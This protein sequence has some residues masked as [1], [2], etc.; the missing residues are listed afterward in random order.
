MNASPRLFILGEGAGDLAHHLARR[1][2]TVCQIIPVGRQNA[3]TALDRAIMPSS[4]VASSRAKRDAS[5]TRT[6]R[7]PFDSIRSNNE[8]QPGRVS[9]GSAPDTP[10]SENSPMTANPARLANPWMACRRASINAL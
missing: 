10:G 4:C 7:T 5:S 1:I 9:M 8:K 3:H 6:V 2:A